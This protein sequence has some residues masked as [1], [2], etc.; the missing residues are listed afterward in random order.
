MVHRLGEAELEHQGLQAA[1]QEGLGV[2]R[3]D[4]IQLVLGLV[5]LDAEVGGWE[6]L[7]QAGGRV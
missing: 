4:V 7:G 5:L 6:R 2:E 1:L 3:Q